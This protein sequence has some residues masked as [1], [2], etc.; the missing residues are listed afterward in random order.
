MTRDRVR[1][2]PNQCQKRP[3]DRREA[4][5]KPAWRADAD[6]QRLTQSII[7]MSIDTRL[8]ALLLAYYVGRPPQSL[9][10]MHSGTVSLA[11]LI[12]GRVPR[13]DIDD[14]DAVA[15]AGD[16]V[17]DSSRRRTT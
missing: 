13:D 7:E 12:C 6:Q 1:E 16:D 14:P 15:A 5:L 3:E 9:D 4:S 11:E 8:L 10:L 17:W 2:G